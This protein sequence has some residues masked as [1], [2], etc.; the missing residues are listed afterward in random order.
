MS[1]LLETPRQIKKQTLAEH[2]SVLPIGILDVSG[3]LHRGIECREWRLKEER[4]LGAALER[5]ESARM[6]QYISTV[7]G[8]LCTQLGPFKLDTMKPA[9]RS[10]IISQMWM[11]DVF[12]VYLWLRVQTMGK[13][14]TLKLTC[15]NCG[16][17]FDYSADLSSVMITSAE[18]IEDSRWDYQPQRAFEMRGKKVEKMTF[19]PARWAAIDA[20]GDK[21]G[22]NFGV[23]KAGLILGSIHEVNGASGVAYAD[24]E[25]DE[26]YKIDVE[27]LTNLIDKMS[28]GPDM[29]VE[30][31]CEKCG[32]QYRSTLD[33]GNDAFFAV[34]SR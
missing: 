9:E 14:L 33:W 31:V 11:P 5:V 16:H 32:K 2:G 1:N 26:M 18:K 23:M 21:V 24:H 29:S 13:I 25:L 28:L 34:S 8:T 7:I 30:D 4:E 27:T 20:L 6:G 3:T 12:F 17:R 10:V 15:P 22:K 19:G